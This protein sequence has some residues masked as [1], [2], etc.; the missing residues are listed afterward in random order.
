MKL[1]KLLCVYLVISERGPVCQ[2]VSMQKQV[3]ILKETLVRHHFVCL[4]HFLNGGVQTGNI[5]LR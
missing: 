3:Q 4:L 5:F 2:L 1:I